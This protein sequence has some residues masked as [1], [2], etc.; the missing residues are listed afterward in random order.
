MTYYDSKA[1]VDYQYSLQDGDGETVSPPLQV[2][3]VY[4]PNFKNKVNYSFTA[5]QI[6]TD[7]Y[8][9]APVILNE[10]NWTQALEKVFMENSQE[11]PSLLWQAFGSATGV[12]RY[13]PEDECPERIELRTSLSSTTA[14][15]VQVFTF[16]VGQHNYDVTPLQWISC[17][18][19]CFYFEIRSICAI[20]INT[21]EYLDVLGRP[22]VLTGSRAKQVQWTNVYQDA[23]VR[24]PS[25]EH[26]AIP[27]L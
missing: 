5:V 25:S 20:R 19:K 3:F 4:D 26:S 8:K 21:Q 15:L 27:N 2:E 23:L 17:A 1:E 12:T 14:Q 7:I 11:D 18:N 22:M 16:S 9:G 24:S 10:L 6:P 13:Y